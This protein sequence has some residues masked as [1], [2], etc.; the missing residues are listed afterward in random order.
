MYE[1]QEILEVSGPDETTNV[2]TGLC[3]MQLGAHLTSVT[4]GQ[5]LSGDNVIEEYPFQAQEYV[6]HKCW[7]D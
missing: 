7:R 1:F 3:R 5:L 6:T 4:S 2:F